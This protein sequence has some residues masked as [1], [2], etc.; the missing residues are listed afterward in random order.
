MNRHRLI[1]MGWGIPAA[2]FCLIILTVI[3]IPDKEL[4]GVLA[5]ALENQGYTMRTSSFGLAFPLG[6]RTKN[7]ELGSDQGPLLKFDRATAKIRILPLFAGKVV[8][9]FQGTIGKGEVRGEFAPL[10]NSS[11]TL[12]IAGVQLE[13]IPFFQTV[14]GAKVKGELRVKGNFKGK[15]NAATGDLQLEV[16]EARL[17]GVKIGQMPLPDA[18]YKAIQGML[19]IGGG[20][21][22]LES[23]NLEGDGLYVRLKGDTPLTTPM[24][25]APLNLTLELM[26]KAEFLDKQ[27]FVFLLLLKYQTSPGHYQIPV[28]GTLG[29]PAVS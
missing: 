19:R 28:R 6:I 16:K 27:K 5:R 15:Q 8:V 22:T 11:S 7:L 12:E 18:S 29:K 14:T 9:G 1:L 2:L 23:L 13:D 20:K 17:Q 24:G 25:A 4:Q 26:P 21:A 3:F 10:K